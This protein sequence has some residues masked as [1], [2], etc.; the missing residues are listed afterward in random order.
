MLKVLAEED[1]NEVV[2]FFAKFVCRAIKIDIRSFILVDKRI[3]S[4]VYS[5]LKELREVSRS[6]FHVGL[7][8]IGAIVVETRQRLHDIV[9]EEND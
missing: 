1:N 3:D 4:F 6:F 7:F 2:E 8:E 5:I 9:A